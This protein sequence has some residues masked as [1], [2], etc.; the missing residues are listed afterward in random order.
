MMATEARAIAAL[1]QVEAELAVLRRREIDHDW[2]IEAIRRC[3]RRYAPDYVSIDEEDAPEHL[4]AL[5]D[6][7]ERLTNQAEDYRALLKQIY[8]ECLLLREFPLEETAVDAA[9]KI[10]GMFGDK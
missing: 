1:K 6:A 4:Q 10:L 3:S 7:C 2:L 8:R 9:N 5:D